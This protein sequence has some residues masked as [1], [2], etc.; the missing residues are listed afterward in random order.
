MI[1]T[2][3][4]IH[5]FHP[6]ILMLIL[7]SSIICCMLVPSSF[8][9]NCNFCVIVD[10][11][12]IV[13]IDWTKLVQSSQTKAAST[14]SAFQRYRAPAILASL[15]VFLRSLPERTVPENPELFF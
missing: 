5:F 8:N 9:L 7:C 12:D 11:M 4:I 3:N 14:G 1:Y 15:G 6:K 10:I 2:V 13:D